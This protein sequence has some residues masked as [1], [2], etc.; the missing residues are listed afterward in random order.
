MPACS[1]LPDEL[2]TADAETCESDLYEAKSQ[3]L[4]GF[5]GGLNSRRLNRAE[6]SRHLITL[7]YFHVSSARN[8]QAFKLLVMTPWGGGG[9]NSTR[10]HYY[11]CDD[12]SE[13]VFKTV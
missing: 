4:E 10:C 5:S 2:K 8:L 1:L 13:M 11:L 9:G 3:R 12:I 7:D 6:R